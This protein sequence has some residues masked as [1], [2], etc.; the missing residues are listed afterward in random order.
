MARGAR[1]LTRRVIIKRL[2]ENELCKNTYIPDKSKRRFC[3]WECS[4][5]QAKLGA[6]RK[7]QLERLL[8]ER[9]QVAVREWRTVT[10]LGEKY[11]LG[12][13]C[14]VQ[15]GFL[16]YTKSRKCVECRRLEGIRNRKKATARAIRLGSNW[17]PLPITKRIQKHAKS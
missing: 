16:R 12:K 4:N 10:D 8:L 13:P 15:H 14:R 7:K 9:A 2:C 1:V 17:A 5:T 11:Y 6:M 3:C